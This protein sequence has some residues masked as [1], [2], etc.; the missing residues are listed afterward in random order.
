MKNINTKLKYQKE[1]GMQLETINEI[2]SGQGQ[3][4]DYLEWLENQ[5]EELFN[6]K[7]K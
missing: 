2:A 5:V 3:I 4:I 6:G 1:T 7:N